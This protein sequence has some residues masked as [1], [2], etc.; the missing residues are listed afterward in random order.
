M[1]II[2]KQ[3]LFAVVGASN[4]TEKYGYRVFNDLLQSGYKVVPI[5]LHEKEILGE[6]VYPNLSDVDQ[7]VNVA[8]FVVPPAA[9][10][11]VL[12]EVKELGIKY[13]WMQPGSESDKA[14]EFCE[15]N[16]IECVYNSCIM[17]DRGNFQ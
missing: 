17:L 4:N 6:K 12:N 9:T 5:N 11:K 10:E 13:V 2:D 7:Q 16:N 15:A 8:V 3:N 1:S 14:V